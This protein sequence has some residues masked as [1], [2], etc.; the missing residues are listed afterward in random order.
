MSAPYSQC[1]GLCKKPGSKSLNMF[2]LVTI[3]AGVLLS[4]V[5]QDAFLDGSWQL[6]RSQHAVDDGR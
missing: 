2:Y 6:R 5:L 1:F 4:D 3:T